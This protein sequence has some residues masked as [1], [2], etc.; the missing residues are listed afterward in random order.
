MPRLLLPLGL[1]PSEGARLGV[2]ARGLL[3]L[4]CALVVLHEPADVT[5]H[6]LRGAHPRQGVLFLRLL[7]PD[8]SVVQD[9]DGQIQELVH[10]E[11]R[12]GEAPLPL[13]F[14]EAELVSNVPKPMQ[15]GW[16]RVQTREEDL[17]RGGEDEAREREEGVD[18]DRGD[19]VW[20]E[21][22]LADHF[23]ANH[24]LL[25]KRANHDHQPIGVVQRLL[26]QRFVASG[27]LVEL[28]PDHHAIVDDSEGEVLPP[29]HLENV[30]RARLQLKQRPKRR[31]RADDEGGYRKHRLEDVG[32]SV[33]VQER[34]C[35]PYFCVP[36]GMVTARVPHNEVVGDG[37][38]AA[39]LH[40][41]LHPL[42]P[43]EV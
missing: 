3:Q 18:A 8:D 38:S 30:E 24:G 26:E 4:T 7:G 42:L 34:Y 23:R 25:V 17:P 29:C 22:Q 20:E 12:V 9:D 21:V 16:A 39:A 13:V 32:A 14:A 43:L 2:E 36:V 40:S 41:R 10:L 37:D 27:P 19:P 31:S 35:S 1:V 28:V 5:F 6:E 11:L 15:V 33:T